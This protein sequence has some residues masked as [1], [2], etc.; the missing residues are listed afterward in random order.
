[1]AFPLWPS[2]PRLGAVEA[3]NAACKVS[4]WG[5]TAYR[6]ISLNDLTDVCGFLFSFMFF[7]FVDPSHERAGGNLHYF[8][9][10]LEEEEEKKCWRITQKLSCSPSKAYTR[11]LWTTLPERDVY[12]SLCRGEGVKLVR[13]VDGSGPRQWARFQLW[14]D[15]CEEGVR[16]VFCLLG[17]FLNSWSY[18]LRLTCGCSL[19]Y[20]IGSSNLPLRSQAEFWSSELLLSTLPIPRGHAMTHCSKKTCGT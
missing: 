4:C 6:I 12:E 11:G 18:L 2:K 17:S 5:K 20:R 7:P 13:H 10:L 1:M 8:E 3:K 14:T 15:R 19:R 9:R 16:A